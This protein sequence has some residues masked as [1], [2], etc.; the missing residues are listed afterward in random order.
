MLTKV[1]VIGK[2]RTKYTYIVEVIVILHTEIKNVQKTYIQ[3][4]KI[5]KYKV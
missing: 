5:I 3:D 2:N 4:S 1:N